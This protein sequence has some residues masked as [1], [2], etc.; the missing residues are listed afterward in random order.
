MMWHS[1]KRLR[2]SGVGLT[3]AVGCVCAPALD[4]QPPVPRGSLRVRAMAPVNACLELQS[5]PSLLV[6]APEGMMLLRLK[7]ELE[8]AAFALEQNRQLEAEQVQRFSQVQR[9]MDSL[10]QVVVRYYRED[11]AP[12]PTVTVRRG[13]ALRMVD[14]RAIDARGFFGAMDSAMRVVGP[15]LDSTLRMLAPSMERTLR[16]MSP[17]IEAVLRTLQ[18]QVAAFTGEAEARMLRNTAPAG[19][20]GLSLTGAQLRTVTSDGVLT[21]H[22]EYPLVETVDVGSPAARAGLSA[23]DTLTAY[24]G[25]DI[26]QQAVNYPELLVPGETVRVR[27]RR[28]GRT[29]ELPVTVVTRDEGDSERTRVFFR[30]P[31]ASTPVPPAPPIASAFGGSGLLFIAGAQF[32]TVDDELAQSLGVEPGV[33]V[34]RVPQGTQ[35]ADAGLRAGDVVRSVNGTA[36]R[37]AATLRRLITGREARLLVQSKTNGART[38]ILGGRP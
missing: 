17:P 31:A 29:R 7:R 10:M 12:G 4:A 20:M 5:S 1:T 13:D 27:V 15:P 18:P 33:L 26:L 6:N 37:D 2:R 19:Y 35:A 34:L 30:T 14:G 11:G 24:N 28:S 36:V 32:A 8:S 38:V 23:G 3:V 16:I 22:C 9:G 21:S 25:R